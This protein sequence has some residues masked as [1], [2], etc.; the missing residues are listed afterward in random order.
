M[1][2]RLSIALFIGIFFPLTAQQLGLDS[3]FYDDYKINNDISIYNTKGFKKEL[4]SIKKE[5][6]IDSNRHT[7]LY[8][9]AVLLQISSTKGIIRK[10]GTATIL[11]NE[12]IELN[13][14]IAEYHIVKAY[15]ISQDEDY[16]HNPNSNTC[17]SILK[18]SELNTYEKYLDSDVYK[19][20]YHR[21]FPQAVRDCPMLNSSD[22]KTNRE[23]DLLSGGYNAYYG[24]KMI[25]ITP[26]M[27][28][29]DDS[30]YPEDK[31][32]QF[33]EF[34]DS[35]TLHSN[36]EFLPDH[37]LKLEQKKIYNQLISLDVDTLKVLSEASQKI[38][39]GYSVQTVRIKENDEI[40]DFVFYIPTEQGLIG[41]ECEDF[42]Y[43]IRDIFK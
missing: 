38:D 41:K 19:Y 25:R 6:N 35:T 28:M 21:C 14:T 16:Y 3:I 43:G 26:K 20:L 30:F 32:E 1:P 17:E 18:A 36:V 9:L 4:K 15:I 12:A 31:I 11:I 2:K 24:Y 34:V 27:V 29:M 42:L 40:F 22:I 37:I 10:Y 5:L 7:N 33:A 39:C 13:N 8:R 23:V